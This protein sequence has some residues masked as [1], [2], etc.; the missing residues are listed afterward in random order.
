MKTLIFLLLLVTNIT[1]AQELKIEP[2]YGFERTYHVEPKPS[3]YR[4][5]VF[6]GMR[7]TYG[8]QV[9]ALE[10]EVNQANSTDDIGGVEAKYNTQ[11]MMFGARLVPLGGEFLSIYTRGGVRWRKKTTELKQTDGSTSKINEGPT[12]DPYAG[13]GVGINLGPAF[14]L[15]ASATL[16]YN[17]NAPAG[18]Q[19][20]TRYTLGAGMKFG[21]R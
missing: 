16:V 1:Y 15:N 7:A 9:F 21:N 12:L 18:E 2:V 13:A 6:L 14:T 20:D 17:R 4:T 10:G 5:E 3:R 19:Y 8:G 11:T